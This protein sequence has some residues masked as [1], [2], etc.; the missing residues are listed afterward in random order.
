MEEKN[1]ANT[2]K[3]MAEE[4]PERFQNYKLSR[5]KENYYLRL[6]FK[7]FFVMLLYLIT[8][9]ICFLGVCLVCW[10]VDFLYTSDD[11]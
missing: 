4:R 10:L 8:M 9:C 7:R 3:K 1:L 6:R 5:G 2:Q 11:G